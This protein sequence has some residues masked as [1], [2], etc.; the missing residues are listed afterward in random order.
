MAAF[1][2]KGKYRIR[3]ANQAFGA[4]PKGNPQIQLI[5]D[6]I[7]IYEGGEVSKFEGPYQRKI[8]LTPTQATLGAPDD[9]G[10][11]LKTLQYLGFNGASFAPLDPEHKEHISFVG[12]EIDA[13][14]DVED[15]EGK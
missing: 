12:L 2:E 4:N 1:Y 11:V 7:G 15:Y 9:P 14:C 8:F 3:I 6:V 5:F 13:R 10:W